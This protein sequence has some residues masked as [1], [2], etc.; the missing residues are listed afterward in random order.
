MRLRRRHRDLGCAE[1]LRRLPRAMPKPTVHI[2]DWFHIAMKIQPMQQIADHIVR[3]RSDLPEAF[4]SIDREIKGVKWRPWHG[5]VDRAIRGLDRLLTRLK[6]SRVQ[7]EFSIARLHSLGSQ[8]LTYISWNRGAIV[9]YGKRY[10]AGLRVATT[11]AESAREFACRQADGQEATNAL[12]AT[13]RPY[14][15]ASPHRRTER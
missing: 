14:A 12:V 1:I 5:R 10:R 15:D 11:L 7:D 3:S 13:R 4:S 9:N 2:I 8:L 6:Q